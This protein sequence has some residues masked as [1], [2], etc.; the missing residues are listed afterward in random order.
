MAEPMETVTLPVGAWTAIC[1]I[2]FTLTGSAGS[3]VQWQ[4]IA[5]MVNT[6]NA[7]QVEAVV[8]KE[9]GEA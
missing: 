3:N 5:G 4:A 1:K 6:M 9:W 8:E 7:A 2:V